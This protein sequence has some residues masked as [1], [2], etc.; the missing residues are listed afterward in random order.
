MLGGQVAE[1]EVY[2]GPD[3]SAAYYIVYLNPSGFVIVAADDLVEPVIGF[4]SGDAFYDPSPE[5]PLGALVSSD[6]PG[7]IAAAKNGKI[8]AG[9]GTKAQDKWGKLKKSD[10]I[11]APMGIGGVSDIRVAPLVQ[12]KWGQDYV[13]NGTLTCYNYYTPNNYYCG[14]TATAMAQIVRYMQYPTAGIGVHQFGSYSTRGGDGSGGPYNYS[15]MISQPGCDVTEAQRQQIGALCYD[16]GV[17]AYMDYGSGGSMAYIHAARTAFVNTFMYSNA[18][19][20]G[21]E[22]NNIGAGLNGMVNPNLDAGVPVEF[23]IYSDRGMRLFATGMAITA[24]RFITMLT[25]DGTATRTHGT[26]CRASIP[27]ITISPLFSRVFT[28]CTPQAPV[29]LSADGSLTV[30]AHRSLERR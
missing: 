15:L 25:W 4:V 22:N 24:R 5:N 21:D 12:T 29:K 14:C 7:R 18:I 28:I 19:M 2:N 8:P 16:V 26:T 23:G 20:G 1:T 30:Q 10:G 9:E 17:A 3:G 6:V 13:C 11:V 27:L